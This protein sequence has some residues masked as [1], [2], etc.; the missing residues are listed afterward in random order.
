MSQ[1]G[2][3][4]AGDSPRQEPGERPPGEAGPS[5]DVVGERLDGL[6]GDANYGVGERGSRAGAQE[7]G[8]EAITD[9]ALGER[10]G[11]DLEAKS[12]TVPALERLKLE[13]PA[14][15]ARA[16]EERPT[17]RNALEESSPEEESAEASALKGESPEAA[18]GAQ[19]REVPGWCSFCDRPLWSGA[20]FCGGC[21]TRVG[22]APAL[23]AGSRTMDDV[24]MLLGFFLA[25]MAI[26]VVWTI[27]FQATENAFAADL[28]AGFSLAAL[29]AGYG[30]WHRSLLAAPLRTAGF[31]LA[32]YGVVL[33]ASVPVLLL[34]SAYVDLL[35]G[36]FRLHEESELAAF[37]GRSVLW[38]LFMVAVLPPLSEEVAFRGILYGGLRRSLSVGEA[39]FLSSFAFAMLHLSVM[40]LFTHLPLGAYF[41]WLRQRSGSV[42]P[43]VFAHACHN[44]GVCL[45]TWW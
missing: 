14:L 5:H 39:M 13:E 31:S 11:S 25:A 24:R 7:V 41:C 33:V 30:L 12:L 36:A 27:W 8:A 44:L 2:R 42:W 9:G 4:Q 6:A 21:G 45:L 10:E 1:Q 23:A 16:L 32:G 20:R 43:G 38:P 37:A 26:A 18:S 17:E 29:T 35:H 19:G 28:G 40:S 3:S 15:E 34:V 22:L